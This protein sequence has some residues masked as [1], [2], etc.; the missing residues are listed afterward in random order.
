MTPETAERFEGHE[1]RECGEHR[2]VGYRAWCFD[3]SEWCY[4]EM[5][6]TRCELP[7]LRRRLIEAE[8]TVGRIEKLCDD[9]ERGASAMR[10]DP[11]H[12][13]TSVRAALRAPES[14]AD[15]SSPVSAATDVGGETTE[16]QEG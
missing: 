9:L 1:N 3:C 5:P 16:A 6:C 11:P 2:T 7:A 12:W 8:S 4:P 14:N 13:V 10:I 15:A